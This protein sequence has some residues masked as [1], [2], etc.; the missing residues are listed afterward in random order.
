VALMSRQDVLADQQ[1]A[2][3]LWRG[4]WR[5][6]HEGV[7]DGVVLWQAVGVSQLGR[8]REN[9]RGKPGHRFA[10]WSLTRLAA[11][12]S[13]RG[14][15]I[16]HR[17][18]HRKRTVGGNSQRLGSH[19]RERNGGIETKLKRCLVTT[20]Y[21]QENARGWFKPTDIAVKG[22]RQ[23]E[24]SWNA[25]LC[26]CQ[27]DPVL[28]DQ[29]RRQELLTCLSVQS[30]WGVDTLSGAARSKAAVSVLEADDMIILRAQICGCC[31]YLCNR[32]RQ[33]SCWYWN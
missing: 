1:C 21:F 2:A 19:D 24:G 25:G 10:I 16:G 27:A 23:A 9:D 26:G 6:C 31:G 17:R 13:L 32:R 22:R 30:R 14:Q 7:A 18:K 3:L 15:G 12:V 33:R 4:A 28:A 8:C 20:N 5:D 11:R 29:I